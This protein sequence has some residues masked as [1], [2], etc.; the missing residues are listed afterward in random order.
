MRTVSAVLG[1][2]MPSMTL[3]VYGHVV[4]GLQNRAVEIIVETA[5]AGAVPPPERGES[6]GMTTYGNYEGRDG[7]LTKGKMRREPR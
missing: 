7:L 5:R 1:H 4:A 6:P 2:S 3:N